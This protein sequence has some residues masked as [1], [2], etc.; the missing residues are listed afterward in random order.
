MIDTVGKFGAPGSHFGFCRQYG[1]AGSEE[2]PLAP[3]GWYCTGS[4]G[5][6]I[7]SVPLALALSRHRPYSS[8]SI[9]V[10]SLGVFFSRAVHA[11]STI[12]MGAQLKCSR[13]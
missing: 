1:I 10:S 6:K 5:Q 2:V 11:E 13:I 7:M 4:L 3:L 8:D 12:E 9:I